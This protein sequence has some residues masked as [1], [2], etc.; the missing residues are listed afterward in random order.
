MKL[1][2]KR[3]L[4]LVEEADMAISESRKLPGSRIM[5]GERQA[6]N[7]ELVKA[8][9]GGQGRWQS[10]GAAASAAFEVLNQYRIEPDEV[11][12]AARYGKQREKGTSN[13]PLARS[14]DDPFAPIPITNTGLAFSWTRLET[15]FEVIAYLG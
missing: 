9:F 5:P 10:P 1:N 13:I 15:G 14:T 11:F 8:G 3:V 12:T 7:K 4:D 6:A 2:V